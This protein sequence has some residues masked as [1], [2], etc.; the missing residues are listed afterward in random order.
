[1]G[2]RQFLSLPAAADNIPHA[3]FVCGESVSACSHLLTSELHSTVTLQALID[4]LSN[5]Q[6][7]LPFMMTSA[8]A[9][10]HKQTLH[11]QWKGLLCIGLFMVRWHLWHGAAHESISQP[12]MSHVG[13]PCA[14]K[15]A[16]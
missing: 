14:Q 12:N 11:R 9:S 6:M 13:W 1:M 16:V 10:L 5:M 7:L 4:I 3:V 8:Y 15:C 2:A